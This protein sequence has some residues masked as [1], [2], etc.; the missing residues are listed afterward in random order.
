MHQDLI[1][2]D[3]HSE[4]GLAA[5]QVAL[6]AL[7]RGYRIFGKSYADRLEIEAAELDVRVNKI[8]ST[9][10][11]SMSQLLASNERDDKQESYNL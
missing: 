5:L 8:T 1:D 6:S 4:H 2:G 11:E 9:W 10:L 7:L 3:I